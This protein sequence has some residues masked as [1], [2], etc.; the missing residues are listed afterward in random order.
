VAGHLPD[1]VGAEVLGS[2]R[3]AFAQAFGTTSVISAVIA[4]SV[5]ILAVALLRRVPLPA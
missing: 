3:D 1:A 5:A 2:A 4:I